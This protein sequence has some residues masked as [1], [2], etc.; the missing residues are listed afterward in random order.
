MSYRNPK[1]APVVTNE[2]IYMGVAKLSEDL[3]TFATA[4]SNRKSDIISESVNTFKEFDDN[5]LEAGKNISGGSDK[6]SLSFL[7]AANNV[8]NELQ[9]QYDLISKTFSTPKQREIA[10]SKIAK[11]NEYPNQVLNDIGTTKYIKDKYQ[12][13]LLIKSG[14]A[15][16]ISLT[17]DINILAIAAD[18]SSGGNNT[19]L[20][21]DKNGNNFYVTKK[22]KETYKLNISQIS[23]SIKADP[24]L[25]VFNTVMDDSSDITAF[26][27]ILGIKS[28]ESIPAMLNSGIIKKEKRQTSAAGKEFEIYTY[29][30]DEAVKRSRKLAKSYIEEPRNY[31]RTNSIWQDKLKNKESLKSALGKNNENKDDVLKKIQDYFIE[32]SISEAKGN[33]LGFSL[34]IKKTEK[35]E[36]NKADGKRPPTASQIATQDLIKNTTESI[37]ALDVTKLKSSEQISRAVREMGFEARENEDG[38]VAIY[39]GNVFKGEVPAGSTPTKALESLAIAS[40]LSLGQAK[41]AVEGS[42]TDFDKFVEEYD[43][44]NPSPVSNAFRTQEIMK[45]YEKSKNK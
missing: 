32:K 1:A 36:P 40:G 5:I 42:K 18:L 21:T 17:N 11:L 39:K 38:D 37:K 9:D 20:E 28:K 2:A 29:D 4:E 23:K 33:Q 31:S 45:A 3:Y 26:Q 30:L 27:N 13:S 44:E 10:K 16:S 24:N 8:K 41:K 25:K 6:V 22:G 14:E 7:E 19:T 12:E 43:K 15:G 34:E 35:K